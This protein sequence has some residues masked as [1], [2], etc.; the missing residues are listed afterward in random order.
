MSALYRQYRPQDLAH[1]VGQRHVVQTLTNAIEQGRVRHAY[2]FAGPRGTGKTSLAKILG[3]SLNCQ[4]FDAPTTTPCLE[5]E[6][7]R[8]IADGTALDVLE[9][10]AAS[11]RGIDDVREIRDRVNQQPVLGRYR[12]YIL[13]E[14]HSLTTDAANALLKTLEE[15]PPHVVFILCTTEPHRLPDT[16]RGRCQSFA[17]LRPTPDELLE[18]LRR[19]ADAESI[20]ADDD[21]LRLIA[22]HAG[23][24]FR[25]AISSL[26]QL[27]SASGGAIDAASAQA[28]LGV[29]DDEVLTQLIDAVNAGDARSALVLLD[30][31]V[32]GGQD[33]SRLIRDL[34]DRL[35]VV[36]LTLE[37]G[38]PPRSA[39]LGST[40]EDA[41][42]RAA[43]QMTEG[44]AIALIDGLLDAESSLRSGADARLA[45][46]ILLI[47][48]ARPAG[49]RTLDGA[50]RRIEALEGGAPARAAAPL[51]PVE[52]PAAPAASVA[53]PAP[54]APPAAPAA[55]P[56]APPA[57]AAPPDEA[58]PWETPASPP[59]APPISEPDSFH[60]DDE[61]APP[62]AAPTPPPVAPEPVAPPVPVAEA[63]PAPTPPPAAPPR[64]SAGDL[65][66]PA[67]ELRD[68]WDE[69][70]SRVSPKLR[71]MLMP[72]SPL[73]IE[74]GAV[75]VAFPSA[76][77]FQKSQ[78]DREQN[79]HELAAALTA[80]LGAE[81]R[82]VLETADDGGP[83]PP[84]AAPP[85]ETQP[86]APVAEPAPEVDLNVVHSEDYDGELDD[87][88]TREEE[89]VRN[90]VETLD[91]SEEEIG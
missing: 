29:V 1:V 81:V 88:H 82:V 67:A 44:A 7:C 2:L 32:E 64:E 63:P 75:V 56:V 4:A 40:V 58:P 71:S 36:L 87:P 18:A 91:A 65:D 55:P 38:A 6:S 68:V 89:F 30:D 78:A 59:A 41:V 39:M 60:A 57:A 70:L 31:L 16:V 21:S 9:L 83:P 48:A 23:G 27:S 12:V 45:L 37:L 72:A 86:A 53:P 54:P 20:G 62:M 85:V 26:D 3:K 51:P 10:D 14:A 13:D 22:R 50:L 69:A 77:Q 49:D 80:S 61:D 42:K 28:I 46:E 73:R 43:T 25:D 79:R 47:K 8:T 17:F 35:R 11:N 90:L 52:A 24:S 34:I 19:I 15:P 76:S 33:L 5:C 84:M 74:R 66:L